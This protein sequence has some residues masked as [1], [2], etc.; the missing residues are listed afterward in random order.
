MLQEH[1]WATMQVITKRGRTSIRAA[2]AKA[3]RGAMEKFSV[4]DFDSSRSESEEL[5]SLEKELSFRS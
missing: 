3:A 5:V 2:A 1:D 4:A